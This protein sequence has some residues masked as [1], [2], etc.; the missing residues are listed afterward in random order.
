MPAILRKILEG[1]KRLGENGLSY[2]NEHWVKI[3]PGVFAN[4]VSF[5]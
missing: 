2:R 1:G 3:G 5:C 4:K